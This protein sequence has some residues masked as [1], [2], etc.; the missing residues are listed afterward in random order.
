ML[1]KMVYCLILVLLLPANI[2]L[3]YYFAATNR[4]ASNLTAFDDG[5]YLSV[6]KLSQMESAE[7][8][9]GR[10]FIRKNNQWLEQ[11]KE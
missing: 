6:K 11:T 4:L 3:A 1:K 5:K 7:T 8:S 2:Y 10:K 9:D